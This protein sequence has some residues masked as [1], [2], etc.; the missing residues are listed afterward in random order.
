MSV[1]RKDCVNM[2][3]LISQAGRMIDVYWYNEQKAS[4]AV[5]I[6]ILQMI[7]MG[8]LQILFEK[9]EIVIA[10]FWLLIRK[11]IKKE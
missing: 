7:E 11:Q 8:C 1:H 6:E 4:Y 5:E 3:D 10:N 9:L 2:K